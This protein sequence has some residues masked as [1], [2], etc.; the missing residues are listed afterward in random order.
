MPMVAPAFVTDVRL[1][2]LLD[3]LFARI[4]VFQLFG[5]AVVVETNKVA[6]VV[7]E[8]VLAEEVSVFVMLKKYE[9]SVPENC[10]PLPPNP[11]K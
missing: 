5:L 4:V 11:T 7:A 8:V 9:F 6:E 3:L 1:L 2:P 10:C